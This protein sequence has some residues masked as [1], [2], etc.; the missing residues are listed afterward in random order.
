[1]ADDKTKKNYR[2][3]TR[4][5]INEDYEKEYWKK[6]FNVSG[7]ALAGA[8]RAVGVSVKKVEKYLKER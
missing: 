8:V 2:D 1:M 4:I 5:N 3:R 7:Q 6:R